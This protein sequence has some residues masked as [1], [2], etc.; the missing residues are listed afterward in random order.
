MSDKP[1][2]IDDSQAAGLRFDLF[3]R[4]GTSLSKPLQ[5]AIA[6]WTR[7]HPVHPVTARR[8]RK[9]AAELMAELA[10]GPK[11]QARVREEHAKREARVA[12]LRAAERPIV[13]DI[14]AAGV[15]ISSVWDLVNT[16]EPYPDALPVLLEHLEQGGYPERVM[17]SLGRALA[18]KPAVECWE[19]LRALYLSARD[20]GEEDGVAVALA[21][22]AT[23][24]QLDD[25][26]SFLS[27][28]VRGDSR[29]Y[30]L[31]PIKHLGG[32]AGREILARLRDDPTFGRE[33]TALLKV[34]GKR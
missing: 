25:L 12:V 16:S 18:V 11:H 15:E 17:E 13:V 4:P 32:E 24:A 3:V 30:F 1:N 7:Q 21:T 22:C 19:R 26:V 33:A 8:A 20:A 34:R 9:T 6:G 14:R 10:S 31:R 29:I 23:K 27:L 2:Y 5:D 28:T